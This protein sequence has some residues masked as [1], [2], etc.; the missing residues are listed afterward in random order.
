MPRR[1]GGGGVPRNASHRF[2]VPQPVHLHA[3]NAGRVMWRTGALRGRTRRGGALQR[4]VRVVE[5]AASRRRGEL[6][7]ALCGQRRTP[8]SHSTTRDTRAGHSTPC[9]TR[10]N[11]STTRITRAPPSGK[12]RWSLSLGGLPNTYTISMCTCACDTHEPSVVY[13]EGG[14][15]MAGCRCVLRVARPRQPHGMRAVPSRRRVWH[16]CWYVRPAPLRAVEVELSRLQL[17]RTDP[18]E[19]AAA[20]QVKHV[21][22]CWW[23]AKW[24]RGKWSVVGWRGARPSPTAEPRR[25]GR[26]G[27]LK[28]ADRVAPSEVAVAGV[29]PPCGDAWGG[30]L[31][32]EWPRLRYRQRA[33]HS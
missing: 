19:E 4:L 12:G 5:L 9:I 25:Q 18:R 28:R 11:H 6:S 7:R 3:A 33:H 26:P 32:S 14:P 29:S 20:C 22:A 16:F 10:A 27:Q 8:A 30:P 31:W 17:R 1:G 23:R 13:R 24:W 15:R 2:P 21:G